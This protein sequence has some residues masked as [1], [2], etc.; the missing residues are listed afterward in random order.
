[1]S[2]AN[3][4]DLIMTAIS[5]LQSGS[6]AEAGATL[7]SLWDR[8]ES[9]GSPLEKCT[10]AHFLADTQDDV[11]AELRWDLR[12]LE[13]ATGF[14]DSIDRDPLAPDLASFLPS[15]HLNVGDAYR[16]AGD[17]ERAQRHAE[18][19]IRRA[20]ALADDG[21]ANTIKAGLDRLRL[22][23]QNSSAN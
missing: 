21:Y 7:L 1:M 10:I 4:M 6:R 23:L 2:K 16:R 3:Y 13:A 12:A 22:R 14:G 20:G 11:A 19:G 8:L 17:C 9:A 5:D 15:L 18:N